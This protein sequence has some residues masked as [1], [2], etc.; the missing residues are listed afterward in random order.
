LLTENLASCP[1]TN[2]R[3][4]L[5][6]LC[7]IYASGG[8][9]LVVPINVPT[10]VSL[11]ITISLESTS[12]F[13]LLGSFQSLV[14]SY[15]PIYLFLPFNLFY[16]P[17]QAQNVYFI[18]IISTKSSDITIKLRLQTLRTLSQIF[19]LIDI[20]HAMLCIA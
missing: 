4:K 17:F 9:L 12:S 5:Y 6:P 1:T 13:I 8:G 16:L 20:Y 14:I 3:E 11:C 2:P 10:L 7:E 19:I 15:I 18:Q